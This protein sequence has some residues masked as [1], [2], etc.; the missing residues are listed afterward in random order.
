[1]EM[2]LKMKMMA[3]CAESQNLS[4][5]MSTR[6]ILVQQLMKMKMHMMS[7]SLMLKHSLLF[8][9]LLLLSMLIEM[10]VSNAS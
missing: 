6:L 10:R 3:S 7:I 5:K 2:K 1:M 8:Q 4:E 9:M